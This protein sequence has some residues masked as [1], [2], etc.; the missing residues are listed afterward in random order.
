ME[1]LE[2]VL[3]IVQSGTGEEMTPSWQDH[4]ENPMFF[5]LRD[6]LCHRRPMSWNSPFFPP[7]KND[8]FVPYF[9]LS[10]VQKV[11]LA[12]GHIAGWSSRY[13]D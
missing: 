5:V 10:L 2:T 4:S 8:N 1:M 9:T 11:P 13:K 6:P 7:D 3:S 12:D